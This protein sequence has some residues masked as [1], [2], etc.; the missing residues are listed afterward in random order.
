LATTIPEAVMTIPA[1]TLRLL[2]TSIDYRAKARK[3]A[4]AVAVNGSALPAV[5]PA[6]GLPSRSS[7]VCDVLH[8]LAWIHNRDAPLP[9]YIHYYNRAAVL[10]CIASMRGG[11][12]WY[13]L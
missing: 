8:R 11:G 6:A 5:R 7:M 10:T 12:I 2:L 13:R 3:R 4:A 1:G 9:S